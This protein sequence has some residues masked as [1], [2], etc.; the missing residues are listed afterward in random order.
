MPE[1]QGDAP[2]EEDGALPSRSRRFS[3]AE[4]WLAGVAAFLFGIPGGVA[5]FTTTNEVGAAAML[6][7]A[8]AFL[9]AAIQGTRVKRISKD[10][11]DLELTAQR[12]D[13][14][15]E[16]IQETKGGEQAFFFVEGAATANPKIR[17]R[18][19]TTHSLEKSYESWV[20]GELEQIVDELGLKLL[21]EPPT[22]SMADAVVA[23]KGEPVAAVVAKYRSGGHINLRDVQ[24]S[25][26]GTQ[27]PTVLMVSNVPFSRE[28][29]GLALQSLSNRRI[30]LIKWTPD[31]DKEELRAAVVRAL[32]SSAA[33]SLP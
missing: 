26:R 31:D 27:H 1:Q 17:N 29:H 18:P 6:L 8:A 9:L 10:G 33:A 4:R 15:R 24:R 19:S 2:Q 22:D 11:V 28:S 16:I 20:L 32:G 3:G 25:L 5:V 30:H 23:K 14:E 12:V 7:P 21:R 13:R